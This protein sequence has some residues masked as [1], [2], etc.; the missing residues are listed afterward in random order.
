MSISKENQRI[1]ARVP[2][3]VYDMLAQAAELMGATMNQF[4]IQ[5][6]REKAEKVIENERL[7]KITTRSAKVFFDAIENPPDPNK[8]LKD[9]VKTYKRVFSNAE[10]RNA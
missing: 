3:N 6:V 7:I 4:L 5:S 8:K 9:A 1:S 2:G 10:S